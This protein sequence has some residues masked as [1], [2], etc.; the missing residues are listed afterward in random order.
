[1]FTDLAFWLG[2]VAGA[3]AVR[4]LPTEAVR[5]RALGLA[6]SSLAGIVLVLRLPPAQ[7]AVLVAVLGWVAF[8][9]G[10]LGAKT[11]HPIRRAAIAVAPVLLLWIAAKHTGLAS[12]LRVLPLAAAGLSYLVVKAWTVARDRADGRA[13]GYDPVT[14]LAYLLFLPTYLSGPMHYYGEFEAGLR[15]PL[16]LRAQDAVHVVYRFLV[17]LLKVQVLA[18][19]LTP[20]SLLGLTG[21]EVATPAQLIAGSLV[22]SVVLYFDFSGYS[23]LA[24]ATA[25]AAGVGAP[26]NFLR[27][28]LAPNIRE[29]WR[30]WHVSFSRVLTSHLFVPVT[31]ALQRRTTLSHKGVMAAGYLV[32]FGLAGYW[33]GPTW[34][35]VV[36]GIYHACGLIA[37]D[38]FRQRRLSA[39]LASGQVAASAASGVLAVLHVAGTLV[40]VSLG[41]LFFVPGLRLW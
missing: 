39:R 22:Y 33:H 8:S 16:P 18:P 1:M 40:F 26:E 13:Q 15:Q 29:F 30:R 2:W 3:C 31:R 10:R 14:G 9:V 27:P 25:R 23:D 4:G 34:R 37:Y 17:G 5:A 24:I 36:W 28:Y 41:W 12:P 20:L 11:E 21:G 38:L 7:A 35:F 19:L 32:T 6:V